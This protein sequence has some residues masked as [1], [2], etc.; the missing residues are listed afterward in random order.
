MDPELIKINVVYIP[1]ATIG[2]DPVEYNVSEGTGSVEFTLRV[3]QGE[4]GFNVNALFFT[5][6]GSA[7]GTRLQQIHLSGII[8]IC[9]IMLS[10]W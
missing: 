5:S 8:I 7:T 4:V 2:F 9:P 10:R 1:V 6:R 3:L